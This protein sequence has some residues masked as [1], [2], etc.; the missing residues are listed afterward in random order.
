MLSPSSLTVRIGRVITHSRPL[1]T[2]RTLQSGSFFNLGGLGASRE[3]QYLSREKG[4]PRTEYS[5]NTHL[6]RSSEVDPFASNPAVAPSVAASRTTGQSTF[7]LSQDMDHVKFDGQYQAAEE[8]SSE[9]NG[10]PNR[11]RAKSKGLQPRVILVSVFVSTIAFIGYQ[12]YQE[13]ELA[14]PW[15]SLCKGLGVHIPRH[16]S[17]T[18]VSTQPHRDATAE[19]HISAEAR[20]TS[21]GTR[22]TKSTT[23]GKSMFSGLFWAK[24]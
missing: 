1:S 6:I 22:P 8:G 15:Q 19:Q 11:L 12:V 5:S 7:R 18:Q 14:E 4:I 24:T 10:D 23:A 13:R 2:T 16:V 21:L 20:L 17:H 9:T 3:A